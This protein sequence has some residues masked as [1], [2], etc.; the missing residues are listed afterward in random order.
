MFADASQG[1]VPEIEVDRLLSRS[2]KILFDQIFCPELAHT[3]QRLV[4]I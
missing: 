1:L 2:L 4:L 3:P